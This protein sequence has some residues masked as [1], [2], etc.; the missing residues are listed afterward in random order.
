MLLNFIYGNNLIA[1]LPEG[2]Q[3]LYIS[4]VF[5]RETFTSH[6]QLQRTGH[7]LLRQSKRKAYGLMFQ[8]NKLR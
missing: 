6:T 4:N 8:T 1:L 3:T 7:G 5:N 2:G